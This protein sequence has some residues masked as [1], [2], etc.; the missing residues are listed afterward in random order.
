[1]KFE[2]RVFKQRQSML[3]VSTAFINKHEQLKTEKNS[4]VWSVIR[5]LMMITAKDTN[6]LATKES[7]RE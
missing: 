1:V 5:F 7:E 2:T 4:S 3:S 6:R